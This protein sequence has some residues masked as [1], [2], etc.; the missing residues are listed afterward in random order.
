MYNFLSTKL[1]EYDFSKVNEIYEYIIANVSETRAKK[2]SLTTNLELSVNNSD[3]FI[4]STLQNKPSENIKISSLGEY[5]FQ[6]Y[7]LTLEEC[8]TKPSK[9]PSDEKGI[10]YIEINLEKSPLELRYGKPS[11]KISPYGMQGEMN[12]KKYLS[13]RK[14]PQHLRLK[15]IVL[16]QDEQ[17]LWVPFVGLSNNIAIKTNPTHI[18]SIKENS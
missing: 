12:L 1:D 11:D 8:R 10:A 13:G 15:T 3:I 18:I 14:I 7:T 4:Y 9:Y 2:I 17:I 16:A 5:I 6:N